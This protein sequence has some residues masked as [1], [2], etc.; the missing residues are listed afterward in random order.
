M[1]D[2]RLEE[3]KIV[4]VEEAF[5]PMFSP[6]NKV[7]RKKLPGWNF[8]SDQWTRKGMIRVFVR[9]MANRTDLLE[10]EIIFWVGRLLFFFAFR[11]SF[12][13]FKR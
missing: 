3:S 10:L 7:L 8:F 1:V 6:T 2:P 13:I 11:F 5:F 9:G 4:I 12:P